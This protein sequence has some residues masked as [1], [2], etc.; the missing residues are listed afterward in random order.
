MPLAGPWEQFPWSESLR[1]PHIPSTTSQSLFTSLVL[2]CLQVPGSKSLRR[3]QAR[4][5]QHVQTAQQAFGGSPLR[6]SRGAQ[7]SPSPSREPVAKALAARFDDS[8]DTHGAG[9]PWPQ[10][11][12]Y[13]IWD[14]YTSLGHTRNAC[15]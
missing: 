2:C 9:Q 1:Q 12:S 14:D 15:N 8:A 6:P 7:P 10:T 11:H 3:L 5:T 4:V 13:R